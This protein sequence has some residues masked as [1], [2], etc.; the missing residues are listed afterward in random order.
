MKNYIRI[1]TGT[2][3]V[4]CVLVQPIIAASGIELYNKA[5]DI[6]EKLPSQYELREPLYNHNN[7]DN[8]LFIPQY[9]EDIN[10]YEHE[11]RSKTREEVEFEKALGILVEAAEL[12]YPEAL[13]AQQY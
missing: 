4:L 12:N 7:I 2:I 10:D 1:L 8:N 13:A 5:I 9:R 6:I 3:Y 11:P